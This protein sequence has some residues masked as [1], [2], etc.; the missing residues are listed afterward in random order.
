MY[1][2]EHPLDLS[3]GELVTGNS[4][5]WAHG[6]AKIP[7]VLAVEL[8]DRGE[9]GFELPAPQIIDTGEELWIFSKVLAK[10]V[11]K[12]KLHK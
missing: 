7:Y 5:D 4:C 3:G 9:H 10:L 6:A 1:K 12:G 2:F 11:L 8:R